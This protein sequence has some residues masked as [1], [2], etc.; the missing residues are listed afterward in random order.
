M[1]TI[2]S[3]IHARQIL[4]SRGNPT[5]E[6]EVHLK[7]GGFGRAAVPSGASTGENEAVELRDG[8][9][10]WCG[11]GV[12]SAVNNINGE[13]AASVIGMD[14]CNQEG[15]DEAMI[16]LD[17][18][19]NKGNLGANA[20]LGVSMATA[21]AAANAAGVPLYSYFNSTA[22]VLPVPM[23][24]ILNGG[25][26]ADNTVDFQE[27]M[28]QPKG[29]D[30][31][32]EGLRASVEI[33]HTLKGV[34][35]DRNL[36]TAV[37]DEGG[38]APNLTDNEEALRV[39]EEAVGRAGYSWGEQIF[40]ALDPATSELVTEARKLGREGYCFFS[41]EP[42]KVISSEDMI[43]LWA[44]WCERYPICSIEDGLGEDDWDGWNKLTRRLGEKIQLVGDDL[45]VT[46]P[47][48]LERGIKD[49]CAN[50]ILIKVNQIGTLTETFAAVTMAQENNY[51]AVLSHRSG[52]TE[53]TTIA[54]ISVATNCGQIKTGAPC[55]SDRT[56]KYNQL[57]RIAEQLG[58][59]ASYGI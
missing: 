5:L 41:S 16:A 58:E 14:A 21:H 52:E 40:V 17:A 19:D 18:T 34:L 39:I 45:F 57:L 1:T 9:Q 11:K 55:R 59:N 26:H 56:A 25:K 12:S 47:R 20:L 54:D 10:A 6:C 44:D 37:G 49:K 53:D 51:S 27:F 29:F 4:D 13:I 38:F 35:H 30:T 31:F 2:I 48:F 43:D 32:G 24:N 28:I 36:S 15:I 33:Y 50:S 3:K 42:D 22:S 46:N 23:F 8:G 7:G